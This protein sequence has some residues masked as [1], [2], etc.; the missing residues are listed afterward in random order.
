VR[1]LETAER[2]GAANPFV[3]RTRESLKKMKELLLADAQK[4][5]AVNTN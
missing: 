3:E 1:T 4:D 5:D 2:I